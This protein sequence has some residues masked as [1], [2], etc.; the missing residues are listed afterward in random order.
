MGT[1]LEELKSFYEAD[2]FEFAQYINPTYMYGD[3]HEEIFS[4]LGSNKPASHELYLLP[5]DHLKS[6]CIACW[7]A[8]QI[9]KEPWSTIVYLSAGESLASN[10]LYAIKGMFQ[11]DQYRLLW[12][13]MFNEVEGKRDKWA[14]FAINTDHPSRKERGVRDNTLIV[15]TIKSNS[16]GLHCSHLVL[17]DIVV[18][19]NAYTTGGRNDVKAAVSQFASIKS[20]GALTKAVGTV[21]HEDDIYSY[22]QNAMV[23]TFDKDFITTGEKHLWK[24][25]KWEVEDSKD[26]DGS[27]NFLWP[28]IF[29]PS[30]KKSFGFNPK[31]LGVKKAEYMSL[32]ETRQFNAQYYHTTNS[33]EFD[34]IGAESF[35]YYNKKFLKQVNG[36][37]Y[38]KDNLLNIF[39]GMDCAFTDA[40]AKGGDRADYTAIV[41][42]GVDKE[43]YIYLL[44][45]DRFKT[46]DWNVYYEKLIAMALY[47]NVRKAR[48][49]TNSGGKFIKREI[50]NRVRMN[51]QILVID[52]KAATKHS[53][54]KAERHS[55]IVEPRYKAGTILHYKGGLVKV[56]EDEIRLD[57]PANDDLEDAL[58]SA[59][60]I[61]SKPGR[62]GSVQQSTSVVQT[63]SSS[64]FGGRRMARGR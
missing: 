34:K 15:R 32:G 1:E 40:R 12:P 44:D 30:L 58:C 21:Y 2:L 13:E 39:I 49:E 43:G 23:P 6:H 45:L 17:D 48:I 52:G 62:R 37:W 20:T 59:I 16:A 55:A 57:K 8:W 4:M 61:S 31:I 41:A 25:T 27:G 56:L 38:F 18:P 9:T 24:V 26:M 33:A 35:Q 10:Q 36:K 54:T 7:C 47:W 64:R 19:R 63:I 50:E 53:G 28:S 29:S 22:F 60:E 42:I 51:G 14:A 46:D 5:R 11:S 3:C